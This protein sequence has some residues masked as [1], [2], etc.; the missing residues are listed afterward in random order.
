MKGDNFSQKNLYSFEKGLLSQIRNEVGDNVTVKVREHT[1]PMTHRRAEIKTNGSYIDG[2]YD[3]YARN[4]TS[5]NGP[6]ANVFAE[7][8]QSNVSLPAIK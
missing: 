5:V 7:K 8:I 1:A 3:K 6:K 2:G 4:S